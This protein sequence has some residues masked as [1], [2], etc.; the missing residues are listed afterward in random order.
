LDG[1]E[2]K[3]NTNKNLYSAK[4][5]DKTRQRRW[6][7]SVELPPQAI[8]TGRPAA[9][10]FVYQ[11]R[12]GHLPPHT[13][14]TAVLEVGAGGGRHLTQRGFGPGCHPGKISKFEMQILAF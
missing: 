12:G 10:Q 5:V 7:V 14:E 3:Y 6:V 4:F 13:A 2:Q 1:F 8:K 9:S 11:H